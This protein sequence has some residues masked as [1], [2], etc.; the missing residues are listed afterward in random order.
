MSSFKTHVLLTAR[1]RLY[2]CSSIK[3]EVERRV[4]SQLALAHERQLIHKGCS[5]RLVVDDAQAVAGQDGA[6]EMTSSSDGEQDSGART[7]RV[8][9]VKPGG[10]KKSYVNLDDMLTNMQ[11]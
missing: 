1:V 7:I 11:S 10:L 6:E 2:V 4:I 5:L 9:L 3:H 8:Q